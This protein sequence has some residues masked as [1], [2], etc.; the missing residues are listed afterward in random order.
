RARRGQTRGSPATESIARLV[1]NES[2][3]EDLNLRPPGP[4][5]AT[6]GTDVR[7]NVV[8]TRC[9]G[10][11]ESYLGSRNRCVVAR[12]SH[13]TS[14]HERPPGLVPADLFLAWL[15][16]HDSPSRAALP[17]RDAHRRC[18]RPNAVLPALGW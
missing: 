4:E 15:V 13:R 2:G 8:L 7:R 3:R 14:H 1:F 16:A 17:V 11:S 18:T 5:A 9:S 6:K 10:H 12:N